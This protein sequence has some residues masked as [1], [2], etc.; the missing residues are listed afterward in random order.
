MYLTSQIHPRTYILQQIQ[1]WFV[2]RCSKSQK[3]NFNPFQA[4]VD[5]LR[6]SIPHLCR[7]AINRFYMKHAD[8]RDKVSQAYGERWKDDKD[9]DLALA[10]RVLIANELW[11]QETDE[12]RERVI[13]E[14]EAQFEK[15]TIEWKTLSLGAGAIE[16]PTEEQKAL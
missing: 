3:A 2:N 16:A 13:K 6:T 14:R 4:L 5:K 12:V 9:E 8:F 7:M 11:T 1:N 15:V 10:C